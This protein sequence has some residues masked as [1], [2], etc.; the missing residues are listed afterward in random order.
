MKMAQ[1]LQNKKG[2]AASV[3][4]FAPR[5]CVG[6]YEPVAEGGGMPA[7]IGA[8]WQDLYKQST[9]RESDKV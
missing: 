7:E 3:F 5:Q 8:Q 2:T 1:S 6:C 4:R 9:S